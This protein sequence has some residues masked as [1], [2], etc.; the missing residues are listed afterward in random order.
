MHLARVDDVDAQRVVILRANAD[1]N[2]PFRVDQPLLHG[3]VK[4][5][6]VINPAHVIIGPC[7]GVG[8]KLQQR[9]RPVFFGVS[10]QDRE[11]DVMVPPQHQRG[12][13]LVQNAG[14]MGLKRRREFGDMGIIKR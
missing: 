10:P 8:V 11:G 6:A 14:D 4:H 2:G 7:V 13:A 1:L 5:G 12:R 9:Q 3:L